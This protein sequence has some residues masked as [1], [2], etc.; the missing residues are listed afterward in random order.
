ML[1]HIWGLMSPD[2]GRTENQKH[3][4]YKLVLKSSELDRLLLPRLLC[5]RSSRPRASPGTPGRRARLRGPTSG[6]T[7]AGATL[8]ACSCWAPALRFWA[9]LL[10][11]AVLWQNPNGRGLRRVEGGRADRSRVS[12]REPVSPPAGLVLPRFCFTRGSL[13][14]SAGF[15]VRDAS[16]LEG[17]MML[18]LKLSVVSAHPLH[19]IQNVVIQ[20]KSPSGDLPWLRGIT[21]VGRKA[22]SSVQP[23]RWTCRCTKPLD[24]QENMQLEIRQSP[25]VKR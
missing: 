10:K 12:A 14:P 5:F 25:V 17:W 19:Q 1:T 9:R 6:C 3:K 20:K 21:Q 13:V 18:F 15:G 11:I 4:Q 23:Q 8:S 7:A 22:E 2:V 24:T 16:K